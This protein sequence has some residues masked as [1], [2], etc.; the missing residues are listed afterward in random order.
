MKLIDII[1]QPI[2][3]INF[4]R[5]WYSSFWENGQ[6]ARTPSKKRRFKGCE[7]ALKKS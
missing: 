5:N 6:K 4:E 2:I 7:K 1:K 3:N